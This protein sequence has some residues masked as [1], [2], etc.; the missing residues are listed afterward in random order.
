MAALPTQA[1]KRCVGPPVM[2][3]WGGGEQAL[4]SRWACLTDVALSSCQVERVTDAVKLIGLELGYESVTK[5]RESL[6]PL[7]HTYIGFRFN[8]PRLKSVARI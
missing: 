4:P 7:L 2:T 3:Y 5:Y 6:V 1:R 8:D